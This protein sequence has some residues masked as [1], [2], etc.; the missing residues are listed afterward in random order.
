MS[1]LIGTVIV[2]ADRL[3]LTIGISPGTRHLLN[4]D[5]VRHCVKKSLV[6]MD[7]DD[8]LTMVLE[9]VLD[10]TGYTR[11]HASET[12][13]RTTRP[14][15]GI[16]DPLEAEFTE[17]WR[18]AG[19]HLYPTAQAELLQ[20]GQCHFEGIAAGK[21]W[22][23]TKNP[24]PP[25]LAALVLRDADTDLPHTVEITQDVDGTGVYVRFENGPVVFVG[26]QAGK[27]CVDAGSF[28]MDMYERFRLPL[29]ISEVVS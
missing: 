7:D 3:N 16:W 24:E 17:R 22:D 27:V 26:V 23:D 2:S 12:G 29:A 15:I 28:K 1:K 18:W 19:H 21:Y 6:S 5:V 25:R 10:D 13:D 8:V 14:M 20:T 9:S 11:A 4:N